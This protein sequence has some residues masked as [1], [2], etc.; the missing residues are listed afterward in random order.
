MNISALSVPFAKVP[1]LTEVSGY[2]FKWA[3]EDK[4]TRGEIYCATKQPWPHSESV[5]I[6]GDLAIICLKK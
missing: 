2:D 5:T 1:L 6:D 3:T 4:A